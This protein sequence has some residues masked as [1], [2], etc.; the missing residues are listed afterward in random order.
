MTSKQIDEIY[1]GKGIESPISLYPNE[2]LHIKAID[3]SQEILAKYSKAKL[4]LW[5]MQNT[6][7]LGLNSKK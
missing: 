1:R 6:K 3:N 4:F 5:N 2:F 7:S